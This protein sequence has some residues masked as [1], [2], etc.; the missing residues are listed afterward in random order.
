[1]DNMIGEVACATYP[2]WPMIAVSLIVVGVLLWK[3]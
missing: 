2:Y 1:M 3:R